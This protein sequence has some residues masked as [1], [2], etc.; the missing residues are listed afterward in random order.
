MNCILIYDISDD[1]KRTK[2]ADVCLDYGLDRFQYSA[3][4]GDLSR[5]HQQELFQKV[6][7]V[8]G[9]KPGNIQLIPICE[10]DW[11]SRMAHEQKEK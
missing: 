3:F 11:Q 7:R 5:N 6:K 9:K 1:R 4:R 10:T 8:L 2:I